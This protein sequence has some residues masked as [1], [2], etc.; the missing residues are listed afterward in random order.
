MSMTIKSNGITIS[1]ER[2][3]EINRARRALRTVGR[4]AA[5]QIDGSLVPVDGL[6]MPSE[7]EMAAM[8]AA[9][10]TSTPRDRRMITA[11]QFRHWLLNA[12]VLAQIQTILDAMPEPRRTS[13]LIDWEY[14]TEFAR[15]HPLVIQIGEALGMTEADLDLAWD[16]AASL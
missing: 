6:P 1:G 5:I 16:H 10:T 4:R 7:E 12:G 2:A 15:T 9:A 13:A 8:L 3:R 14:G 11:R